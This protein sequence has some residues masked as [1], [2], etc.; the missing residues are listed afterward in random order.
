MAKREQI[1]VSVRID[2]ETRDLLERA[3]EVD[4]RSMSNFIEVLILRHCATNGIKAVAKRG[5]S[6]SKA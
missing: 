3:A 2:R 6:K 4:R 1:T 5:G